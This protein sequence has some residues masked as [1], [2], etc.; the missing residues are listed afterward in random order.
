MALNLFSFQNNN[1]PLKKVPPTVKIMF[2]FAS[3]AGLFFLEIKALLFLFFFLILFSL[4]LGFSLLNQ[5]KDFISLF[6]F[7]FIFYITA[8]ITNFIHDPQLT[9]KLLTPSPQITR[10]IIHLLVTVELSN[11]FYKTTTATQINDSLEQIEKNLRNFLIHLPLI[12][13]NIQ[14]KTSIVFLF[15]MILIFI[16]RLVTLWNQ[17]ELAWK[18]RGGK[19]NLVMFKALFPKLFVLA[20]IDAERTWQAIKNRMTEEK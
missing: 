19:S 5:L 2:L 13:K 7:L 3:L 9:T 10:A 1:S 14:T 4:V 12:G 8:I 11:L 15:S 16:L 20:F 17:L 18:A 6:P